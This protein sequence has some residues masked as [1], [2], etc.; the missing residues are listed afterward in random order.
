LFI[1]AVTETV[2]RVEA[3]LD[4]AVQTINIT[5]RFG[6]LT[7]VDRI[8]LTIDAE[9]IFGLLGP[10]GA[11]KTTL[12][13]MLTT[14]LLLMYKGTSFGAVAIDFA[15]LAAFTAIMVVIAT[16]AFKRAL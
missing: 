14:V 8:N 10:N 5:K 16:L 15:F 7:A 3:V 13:R 9:E 1:S 2:S 4:A 11:G 12:I 6:E